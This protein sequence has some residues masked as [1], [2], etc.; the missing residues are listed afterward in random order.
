MMLAAHAFSDIARIDHM[1]YRGMFVIIK[2]EPAAN[3]RQL[4][5]PGIGLM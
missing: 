3:W 5:P 4:F 2:A 1:D